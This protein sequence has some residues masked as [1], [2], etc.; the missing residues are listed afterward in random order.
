[1]PVSVLS[2]VGIKSWDPLSELVMVT[3]FGTGIPSFN[4][5]ISGMGDA[6][7]WQHRSQI[8]ILLY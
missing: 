5:N 4:Q 8:N 3:C 1:M 2:D 7:R 6:C